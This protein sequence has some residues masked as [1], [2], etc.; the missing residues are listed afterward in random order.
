MIVLF[1]DSS[2]INIEDMLFLCNLK[3]LVLEYPIISSRMSAMLGQSLIS[4]PIFLKGILQIS[5]L[6]IIIQVDNKIV[7]REVL[8]NVMLAKLRIFSMSMVRPFN[9]TPFV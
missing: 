1:F 6:K 2:C 8:N 5:S 4:I 9:M 3:K 7:Y